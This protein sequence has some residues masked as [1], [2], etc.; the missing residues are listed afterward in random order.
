MSSSAQI[1]LTDERD[2]LTA[3]P[4]ELLHLIF[5]YLLPNHEPDRAFGAEPQAVSPFAKP[6]PIQLLSHSCKALRAEGNGWARHWLKAHQ[7]I[8]HY[9]ELRSRNARSKKDQRGWLWGNGGLFTWL[10]K[11]CVFCGKTS[12]RRA[13]L[14]NGL[15]CCRECDRKQWPEKITK[16]AAMHHYDLKPHHLFRPKYNPTQCHLHASPWPRIQYGTYMSSNVATTMFLLKDVKR[17][18]EAVHGDLEEHKQKKRLEKEERDSKKEERMKLRAEEAKR[19]EAFRL[20]KEALDKK[21]ERDTLM[22]LQKELS[23]RRGVGDTAESPID[24]SSDDDEVAAPDLIDLSA[25]D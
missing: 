6:H 2:H 20:E 14:A 11:H 7:Q 16:T 23:P 1:D 15:M 18:A 13:I 4:A 9:K 3:L 25:D 19:Q 17:L 5:D 22:S 12:S 21:R 24:L 10:G 8:T